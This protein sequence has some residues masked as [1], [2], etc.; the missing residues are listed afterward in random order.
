LACFQFA[1]IVFA[2]AVNA[3]NSAW[4]KMAGFTSD[5]GSRNWQ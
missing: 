5:R 2:A 1:K 4:P 3:V